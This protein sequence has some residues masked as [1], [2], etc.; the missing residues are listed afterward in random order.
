M[1]VHNSVNGFTVAAS[2]FSVQSALL[3]VEGTKT[4]LLF[5]QKSIAKFILN[6]REQSK[7]KVSMVDSCEWMLRLHQ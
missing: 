4:T 3:T 5:V 1:L 6:K 2:I 7:S